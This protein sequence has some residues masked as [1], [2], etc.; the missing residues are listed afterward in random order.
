[1]NV[2][3]C[4]STRLTS[5]LVAKNGGSSMLFDGTYDSSSRIVAMQSSSESAAKCATP[6]V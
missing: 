3:S 1:M 6:D 2:S 5:S 4:S